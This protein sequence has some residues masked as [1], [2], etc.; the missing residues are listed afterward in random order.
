MELKDLVKL[1]PMTFGQQV[2]L[3]EEIEVIIAE[4]IKAERAEIITFLDGANDTRDLDKRLQE[5]KGQ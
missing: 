5:L 1:V 2:R 3:L 4:R